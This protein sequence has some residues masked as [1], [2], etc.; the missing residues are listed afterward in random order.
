[1]DSMILKRVSA[2]DGSMLLGGCFF[3]LVVLGEA[4]ERKR[5]RRV[6]VESEKEWHIVF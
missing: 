3:A 5:R 2:S 6:R 1:M 4:S